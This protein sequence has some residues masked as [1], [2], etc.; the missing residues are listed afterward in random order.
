MS[1]LWKRNSEMYKMKLRNIKKSNFWE[2]GTEFP[3]LGILGPKHLFGYNF[4][5]NDVYMLI[6]GSLK[7]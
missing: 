1:A 6:E 2:R 4:T 5:K 7:A 3:Y